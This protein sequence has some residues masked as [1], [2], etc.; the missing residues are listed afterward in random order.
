VYTVVPALAVLITAGDHVPFIPFA[1]VV[2]R[3]AGVS[4][5]QYGPAWV[6]VG[7][8]TGFTV[9]ENTFE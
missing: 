1:D 6:N 8:T 3:V 5:V 7:V 2:A 9:I 4:P